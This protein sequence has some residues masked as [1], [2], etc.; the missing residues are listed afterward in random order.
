MT[1]IG[2]AIYIKDGITTVTRFDL[3]DPDSPFNAQNRSKVGLVAVVYG[4][5][6][7]FYFPDYFVPEPTCYYNLPNRVGWWNNGWMDV[8]VRPG[9]PNIAVVDGRDFCNVD[10]LTPGNWRP[11]RKA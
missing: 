4:E 10:G 1:N 7:P 3:D 11:G 8:F 5:L 6:P 9:I 2:T